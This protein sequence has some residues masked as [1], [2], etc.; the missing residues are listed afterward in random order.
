MAGYLRQAARACRTNWSGVHDGGVEERARRLLGVW[1]ARS[2]TGVARCIWW[3]QWRTGACIRRVVRLRVVLIVASELCC[4]C[5]YPAGYRVRR[6]AA[7]ILNSSCGFWSSAASS[8]RA[9]FLIVVHKR[10]GLS[11]LVVQ[12]QYR[13]YLVLLYILLYPQLQ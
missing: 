1:S 4:R 7:E 3:P 13:V 8:L 9:L 6:V 5:V 11:E 12:Q 2:C 10:R